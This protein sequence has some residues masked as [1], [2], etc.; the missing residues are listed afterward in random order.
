MDEQPEIK[1]FLE[2]ICLFLEF[3]E[4]NAKTLN[5]CIK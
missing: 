3:F 5:F 1:L 2:F 4:F